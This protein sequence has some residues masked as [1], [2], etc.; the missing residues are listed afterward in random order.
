MRRSKRSFSR[1]QNSPSAQEA[2]GSPQ[3]VELSSAIGA[4]SEEHNLPPTVPQDQRGSQGPQKFE[5]VNPKKKR[6]LGLGQYSSHQQSVASSS[7]ASPP[8]TTRLSTGSRF[9]QG[10]YNPVGRFSDA[11]SLLDQSPDSIP[12]ARWSAP[13][14]VTPADAMSD[15]SSEGSI[16][17]PFSD[18]VKTLDALLTSPDRGLGPLAHTVVSP[19]EEMEDDYLDVE[20]KELEESQRKLQAELASA[21]LSVLDQST[22]SAHGAASPEKPFDEYDTPIKLIRDDIFDYSFRMSGTGEK[23]TDEQSEPRS[24]DSLFDRMF[25]KFEAG[26][27]HND[28]DSV[29]Y[30]PSPIRNIQSPTPDL[31]SSVASAGADSSNSAIQ[32]LTA[33]SQKLTGPSLKIDQ[34]N[35]ENEPSDTSKDAEYNTSAQYRTSVADRRAQYEPNPF[36]MLFGHTLSPHELEAQPRRS[37]T[38]VASPESLPLQHRIMNM[39]SESDSRL[40]YPEQSEMLETTN[41]RDDEVRPLF[42][43]FAGRSDDSSNLH[44][45]MHTPVVQS[46]VSFPETDST[47]ASS[48]IARTRSGDETWIVRALSTFDSSGPVKPASP[49][50]VEVDTNDTEEE[51]VVVFEM[52]DHAQTSAPISKAKTKEKEK[53]LLNK[54]LN[55]D[56]SRLDRS[57]DAEADASQIPSGKNWKISLF[58]VFCVLL[59]F[60]G[61][62]IG[63]SYGLGYSS[64]EFRPGKVPSLFPSQAPSLLPTS[65]TSQF[66]SAT[67]L[68]S[69]N[70]EH[71]TAPT[72]SLSP[73]TYSPT[74][75]PTRVQTSFEST[76]RIIIANGL[77][78]S[79]PDSSYIPDLI[80]SMNILAG[81]VLLNVPGRRRLSV[82]LKLPT[83]IKNIGNIT[84][85]IPN[86]ID[87][88]ELVVAQI[89]LFDGVEKWPEF[90]ITLDLAIAVGRLQYFLKEVDPN[91][92][93]AV[94]NGTQLPRPTPPPTY[95]PPSAF[96]TP[97]G[98]L[99]PTP[100][101]L[102]EYLVRKSFDGG[103]ALSNGTSAQHKAFM[104]LSQEANLTSYSEVV[105]IQRFVMATLYYSTKGDSWF[106]NDGWLSNESECNWFSKSGNQGSCNS[107]GNVVNLEIDYNNLQGTVPPELGLLSNSLE[108]INFGGGPSAFLSGTLPSELGYLTGI[109]AFATRHNL[110]KGSIPKEFGSWKN[111]MQLDLSGNRLS[112]SLPAEI[113]NYES[114]NFLDISLNDLTGTIPTEIGFLKGCQMLFL[115]GNMF[116]GPFPSEIGMLNKLQDVTASSNR[117]T[118]LP[119]EIGRLTFLDTLSLADNIIQGILPPSI[120]SLPRLSKCIRL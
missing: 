20:L 68:P 54:D 64:A 43:M 65:Q 92:P 111:I 49:Q 104:W 5:N 37:S 12:P 76:Y 13:G 88:C 34:S 42:P 51:E 44:E 66:H 105:I 97:S 94:L 107:N 85:P 19:S 36:L 78:L 89:T 67:L 73:T 108:R 113:G 23:R 62:F 57:H 14:A 50:V 70:P 31:E 59:I 3:G 32:S 102:F 7:Y 15:T 116:S 115:D 93:V 52:E 1:S 110:I 100:F 69:S 53:L 83:A 48:D 21:N 55:L 82:S 60:A 117:L 109:L 90:K 106:R 80:E 84:C 27:A 74:Q 16:Q 120:G 81:E 25:R 45:Q 33:L 71:T 4:D 101:N 95:A 24:P 56:S 22:E 58:S 119:S 26:N 40:F 39:S 38:P 28:Q 6:S 118:S 87:R 96:P 86:G 99:L 9:S 30:V 98:T 35:L 18:Q 17:A 47:V 29:E 77:I 114:L 10:S 61:I 2:L 72:I 8:L 75:S 79:V 112:G 46:A 41:D 103:T 63:L 91:S 11:P